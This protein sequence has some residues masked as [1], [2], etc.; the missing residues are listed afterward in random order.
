MKIHNTYCNQKVKSI[1]SWWYDTDKNIKWKKCDK[2]LTLNILSRKTELQKCTSTCMHYDSGQS[3]RCADK[4]SQQITPLMR[5]H[6]YKLLA[7]SSVR[8]VLDRHNHDFHLYFSEWIT[9]SEPATWYLTVSPLLW[10]ESIQSKWR[11][12]C[13]TLRSHCQRSGKQKGCFK[14]KLTSFAKL[15]GNSGHQLYLPWITCVDISLNFDS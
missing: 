6:K 7:P 2:N 14:M 1:K 5:G 12:K 10:S 4:G 15:K 13:L 9:F 11:E 8:E 3:G